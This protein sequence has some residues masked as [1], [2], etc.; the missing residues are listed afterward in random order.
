MK[1][2]CGVLKVCQRTGFVA[3]FA[4]VEGV[5]VDFSAKHAV[6][7][8]SKQLLDFLRVGK[9]WSIDAEEDSKQLL[10]TIKTCLT[11]RYYRH[12]WQEGDV[13]ASQSQLAARVFWDFIMS[14]MRLQPS[15]FNEEAEQMELMHTYCRSSR[16]LHC[17]SSQ[18]ALRF[19]IIIGFSTRCRCVIL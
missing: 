17:I 1:P 10:S 9:C 7:K 12:R 18:Q 4:T 11:G 3:S 14:H 2:M 5:V 13:L 15:S 6:S 16:L 19:G 8:W